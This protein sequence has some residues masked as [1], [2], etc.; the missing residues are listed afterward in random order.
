VASTTAPACVIVKHANPCGVAIGAN[1][2]EAYKRAL[3]T[4]PTSAFGGIIAFNVEVDAA[5]A[6][7][8]MAKLFV[9]V[10]IAPTFTA[11][12]K[13]ILSAKQNVRLLEIPLG[14]GQNAM[15]FKRVGGGLLVQ[16]PDSKNVLIADLRV[17]SASCSRPAAAAGPDVR[18]ARG[19]VRQV[20]RDRLLR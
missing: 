18:L 11:E 9:E 10:L 2:V 3:Q 12:A 5:A 17:V 15:D 14:N 4:D 19:Q 8:A 13:Q 16:S 20:E 6:T 7:E 1:A